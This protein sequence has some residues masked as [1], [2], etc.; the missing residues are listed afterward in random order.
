MRFLCERLGDFET[1]V[2]AS[3]KE[4]TTGHGR[5]ADLPATLAYPTNLPRDPLDG[6][7][8][9]ALARRVG[10]H[11]AERLRP[12]RRVRPFGAD[13]RCAGARRS[14]RI[15]GHDRLEGAA[16]AE[17]NTCVLSALWLSD[18]PTR[19]WRNWQTRRIQD[20]TTYPLSAATPRRTVTF[21]P[22]STAQDG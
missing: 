19:K 22:S 2:T 3:D 10:G 17:R 16:R 14:C 11:E 4:E 21:P 8:D 1:L 6:E 13:A 15:P 7:L 5:A 9:P 18:S 12:V 20:R